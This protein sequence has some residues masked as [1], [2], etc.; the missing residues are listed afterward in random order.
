LTVSQMKNHS[1][2]K[3]GV[4]GFGSI[5]SRHCD[6]LV[7]LG[8]MDITLFREK[9]RE[10]QQ[11]F[12]EVYS[13]QE[14]LSGNY[15]FIILA[16]PTA[17]HYK[18]LAKLIPGQINLLVEKPLLATKE[19]YIQLKP[20]L[21]KYK[22][23]GMCAYNLRFH[24]C[25]IKLKEILDNNA[26]GKIY[27]AR[28]FVGQYLPDWH[29]E[30]D[31]RNTY[32][33][34]KMLGGGVVLDLIHEIDLANFLFGPVKEHFHAIVGKVSDLEIET[35][36]LVEIHYKSY[37]NAYV[38]IHMDYLVKG[39][40][41]YTEIIAEK[42]RIYC[43]LFNNEIKSTAE[44]N[45]VIQAYS[46]PGF[47]RNDMYLSMLEYYIR[48]IEEKTYPSPSLKDGLTSPKVALRTKSYTHD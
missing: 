22:A 35:E 2:L 8:I 44:G 18:F 7:R 48:N 42:G 21:Q 9:G 33:A 1:R 37:K 27:S 11:G 13:F 31:Y 28:L 40:S 23:I 47:K 6:N 30:K 32:S 12:K 46:F 15:D 5:G 4:I 39:Y 26:L 24:P 16:N 25:I 45:K 19:E 38:S 43:D 29:P 34:V 17:L 3:V 20:T 41:R 36:D 10:N 14:F